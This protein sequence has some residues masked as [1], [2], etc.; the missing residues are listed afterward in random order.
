MLLL[1]NYKTM[2]YRKYRYNKVTLHLQIEMLQTI[3]S[4][5]ITE[6]YL[7]SSI[8][9]NYH[10]YKQNQQYEHILKSKSTNSYFCRHFNL[11]HNNNR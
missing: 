3:E 4:Y 10:F 1:I 2:I 6:M 8:H 11:N 7:Y 9:Y 5:Y